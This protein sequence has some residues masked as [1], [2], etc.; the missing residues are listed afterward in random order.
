MKLNISAAK[1][2]L[3]QDTAI[4]AQATAMTNMAMHY[5]KNGKTKIEN[6]KISVLLKLAEL[7]QPHSGDI[8]IDLDKVVELLNSDTP[9]TL[10]RKHGIRNTTIISMRDNGIE[11]A[12]LSTVQKLLKEE[13]NTIEIDRLKSLLN[14]DISSSEIAK[15]CGLGVREVNRIRKISVDE[16]PVK[17]AATLMKY[18]I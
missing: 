17:T 7:E 12:R 15:K 4:L 13:V 18:F 11:T 6:Q 5:L 9:Y 10:S 2:A 14:S 3:N 1:R 8:I 16:L